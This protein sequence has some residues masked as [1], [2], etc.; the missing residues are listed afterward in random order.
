VRAG[1]RSAAIAGAVLACSLPLAA[2]EAA[3]LALKAP[4][5]SYTAA[6]GFN[7]ALRGQV[8]LDAG[9]IGLG[10]NPPGTAMRSGVTLR[11]VQ[12]A[13]GGDLTDE[14]S[15]NA[16]AVF[17]GKGGTV[18]HRFTTY[19]QYD[20]AGP[21]GLRVGI[22]AAPAGI[23]DSAGSANTLTFERAS[24]ATVGRSIAGSPSRATAT[25]FRQRPTYLAALSFTGG[26]IGS[27]GT[28]DEQES[29]QARAAWLAVNND[30]F[31]WLLDANAAHVFK[32]K[33]IVP[34]SG[35]GQARLSDGPELSLDPAKTVD[36]GN[37]DARSV[38]EW[39]VETVATWDAAFL[40]AGYFQYGVRRPVLPDAGFDAW[41]VQ[42]SWSLT[43]DRRRYNASTATFRAPVPGTPLGRDGIG[44]VELVARY[45]N[46]DLNFRPLD[47]KALGAVTGGAQNIL[48]LGVNWFP[49]AALRLSL[50]YQDFTVHH[51]EA[52]ARDLG[53]DTLVT[54][55]QI[56]F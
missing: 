4:D 18:D 36:T 46:M 30:D 38:T 8:I 20:G 24:A 12:L 56:L 27:G 45:S 47:G 39:G 50:M 5:L 31:H 7:L 28:F 10:R 33:E 54:R 53:A 1:F 23:E 13:V 21:V 11:R 9:Y 41:Y 19:L 44:A 35:V 49:N 52:P 43:G 17:P 2:Q 14:L 6:N 37:I 16:G 34:G 25:L 51:P 42:A 48:S 32:L 29:M 3:P 22:F 26:K 15:Y 40:Q 55:A